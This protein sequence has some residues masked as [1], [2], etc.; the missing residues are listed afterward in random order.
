MS[1][2]PAVLYSA[3]DISQKVAQLVQTL[4]ALPD[5][6]QVAAPVL[7]GAFVFAAQQIPDFGPALVGRA[8]TA[9]ARG[10]PAS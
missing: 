3:D 5:R 4:A 8:R 1:D 7:V 6:P 10:D 2:L 9:L